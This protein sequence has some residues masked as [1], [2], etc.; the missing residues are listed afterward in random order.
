M[1]G[2]VTLRRNS[3]IPRLP[4][5]FSQYVC[6]TC[7]SE[8]WMPAI[9]SERPRYFAANAFSIADVTSGESGVTFGSNRATIC[10]SRPIKNFVKFH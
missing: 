10:P 3:R 1:K 8:I 2:A 6:F 7:S 4:R 9:F 5:P